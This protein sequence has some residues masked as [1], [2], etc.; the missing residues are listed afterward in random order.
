MLVNVGEQWPPMR[1]DRLAALLERLCG[2]PVRQK[3]SHRQFAKPDGTGTFTF[4]FSGQK[5]IPGGQVRRILIE[6]AGLSSEQAREA[7]Q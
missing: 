7:L 6:N 1:A 2:R 5:T 3:G 4:A